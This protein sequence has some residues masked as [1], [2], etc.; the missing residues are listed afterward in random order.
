MGRGKSNDAAGF[1]ERYELLKGGKDLP[2][3]LTTQIKQSTLS[4]YKAKD[5]FPRADEAVKIA[6]ALGTT[7]EYMASGCNP[8]VTSDN[9]IIQRIVKKLMN[10]GSDKLE[11]ISRIIDAIAPEEIKKREP[12]QK[13]A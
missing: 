8:K 13:R 7:V 9:P 3:V 12:V 10:L 6:Q 4:T 2:I 5:R 1:W 11:E